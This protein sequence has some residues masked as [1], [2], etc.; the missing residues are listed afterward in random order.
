MA[1]LTG[2]RAI[3]TGA[4]RGIGRAIALAFAAEDASLV[5]TSRSES[6]LRAV[7]AEARQFGV[8]VAVIPADVSK[9]DDVETVIATAGAVDILVNNAGVHGPVG[10]F[11]D[12]DLEQ[13]WAAMQINL[14]GTVRFCQGVIPGMVARGGGRII[15]LS[16]GGATSPRPNLAA[17]SVS[18]TAIVRL[19]ENL[20][21]E[22]RPFNILVN[23][24]APGTVNT[25]LHDDVLAAGARA[26]EDL[27][28]QTR[29]MRET[30]AGAVLPALVAELAVFLVSAASGGLTGKLISAP[31]D[32]W[33]EW[34]DRG[35][36]IT[37]SPLYT[38]RRLDPFTLRP[39]KHLV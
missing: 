21:E 4:G 34:T 31:H 15:N 20:A 2:K 32:P 39:L 10:A 30:G 29:L 13:W 36:E 19:T 27:G 23:A 33:R 24:I 8:D 35:D 17:Y 5:I 1:R 7:A 6:E 22:L 14:G 3:V 18:K 9:K 11:S 16:G 28:R 37:A 38:L 12:A 26:G 25:R